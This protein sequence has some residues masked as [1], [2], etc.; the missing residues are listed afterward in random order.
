MFGI[1][2]LIVLL[3]FLTDMVYMKNCKVNDPLPI[4]HNYF[5]S[6][7]LIM[8]AITSLVFMPSDPATFSADP[9]HSFIREPM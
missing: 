9:H 4:L 5:Q 1:M 3:L 8:G 7:D 2:I 6:G